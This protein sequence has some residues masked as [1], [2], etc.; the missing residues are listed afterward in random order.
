MVT[1][2]WH[3]SKYKVHKLHKEKKY[4][5][6]AHSHIPSILCML[7]NTS[8]YRQNQFLFKTGYNPSILKL[9]QHIIY[10]QI[11]KIA[12]SPLSELSQ[13]ETE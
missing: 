7:S 2:T 11:G 13:T 12:C 3:A 4:H 6:V 1:Q 8:I 9:A 10:T 5:P